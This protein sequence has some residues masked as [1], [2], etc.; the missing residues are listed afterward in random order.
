MSSINKFAS[1]FLLLSFAAFVTCS[2]GGSSSSDD[3]PKGPKAT[4]VVILL[5]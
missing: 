2:G 1:S 4:D 3:K 5:Q